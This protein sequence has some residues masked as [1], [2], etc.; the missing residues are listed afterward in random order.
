MAGFRKCE[1]GTGQQVAQHLDSYKMMIYIYILQ[2]VLERTNPPAFLIGLLFK[3]SLKYTHQIIK[4]YQ[5]N[6]FVA[7]GQ[8]E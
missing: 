2:E 1:T 8:T 7:N 4:C 3:D 6:L 5:F